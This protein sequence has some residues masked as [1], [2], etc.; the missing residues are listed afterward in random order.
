[1]IL[2]LDT[3]V[4]VSILVQE[5]LSESAQALLEGVAPMVLVSDFAA[6]EF[7]SASSRRVRMA[8]V[9]REEAG[10]ILADFD[11]WLASR[12]QAVCIER[13]DI[14]A[15]TAY[16]RRFD[17]SLRTLDALHVAAASRLGATLATL[18]GRMAADARKVG[19]PTLTA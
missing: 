11:T 1:M 17:L 10:G 19:V 16:L 6:A 13:E 2:Y 3:S 5:A 18:D 15:A 12:S 7:V 9:S 14:A 4:L 8:D